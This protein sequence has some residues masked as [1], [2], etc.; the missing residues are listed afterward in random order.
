[1]A[2]LD[3]A[4]QTCPRFT[5]RAG[6]LCTF[7]KGERPGT[8]LASRS[9]DRERP[10]ENWGAS[11]NAPG[12]APQ[13]PGL[14]SLSAELRRGVAGSQSKTGPLAYLLLGGEGKAEDAS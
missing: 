8:E 11:L 6:R 1:M 3:V 12:D 13:R 5:V 7:V 14:A 9:S 4:V 10:G 2:A